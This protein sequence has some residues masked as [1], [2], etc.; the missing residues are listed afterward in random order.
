MD[1]EHDFF[2]VVFTESLL[3]LSCRGGLMGSWERGNLSQSW[4]H[5]NVYGLSTP[6]Q[7]LRESASECWAAV[8]W[9]EPQSGFKEGWAG[10]CP[11]LHLRGKH[12]LLR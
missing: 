2:W 12:S 4:W 10:I 8:A 11:C 7:G 1:V 5:C 3:A 6:V 9:G